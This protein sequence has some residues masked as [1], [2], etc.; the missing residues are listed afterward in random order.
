M[1]AGLECPTMKDILDIPAPVPSD[2][3]QLRNGI[4][5]R[6]EAE[7]ERFGGVHVSVPQLY[8]TS[9]VGKYSAIAS[10]EMFDYRT[11]LAFLN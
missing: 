9:S 8:Y 2:A 6:A 11:A 1:V 4:I 3:F 10:A 7:R 5:S